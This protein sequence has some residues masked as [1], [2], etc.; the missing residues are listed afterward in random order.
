M[1]STPKV[2]FL[3]PLAMV[4]MVTTRLFL[5]QS[6]VREQLVRVLSTVNPCI[7]RNKALIDLNGHNST[8][9]DKGT[10][11]TSYF[12]H[13]V[14]ISLRFIGFRVW[15]VM[16]DWNDSK[17]CELTECNDCML[18]SEWP[19]WAGHAVVFSDVTSCLLRT[20]G[21]SREQG[22]MQD[23]EQYYERDCW[24]EDGYGYS[25]KIESPMMGLS[26]ACLVV[27]IIVFVS[28]ILF[29]RHK[30]PSQSLQSLICEKHA[31]YYWRVE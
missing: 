21:S 31:D 18:C 29:W 24:Q 12:C 25:H 11:M 26:I 30:H 17:E 9:E 14:P 8:I 13:K 2:T 7:N 19:Q 4:Y 3:F 5:V 20:Q 23:G 1:S 27:L 15:P 28:A 6:Y 10:N 16:F 22:E